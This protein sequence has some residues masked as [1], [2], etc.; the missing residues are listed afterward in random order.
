MIFKIHNSLFIFSLMT[1][2]ILTAPS[3]V[4]SCADMALCQRQK[5]SQK[6]HSKV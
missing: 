5:A 3:I 2:F 1:V 6:L 4:N